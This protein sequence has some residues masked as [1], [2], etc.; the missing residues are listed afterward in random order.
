MIT[1]FLMIDKILSFKYE[2]VIE[3]WQEIIKI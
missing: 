1:I 2:L 3:L